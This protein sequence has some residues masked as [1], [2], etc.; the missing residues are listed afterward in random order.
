VL[1]HTIAKTVLEAAIEAEFEEHVASTS[2]PR[3]VPGNARNG[4]RSKTVRTIVGPI[5]IDVP[6]DRFG[7]FDPITVGKWQRDVVG[8]DRL[9]L[10]IVAK[11][12][13]PEKTL[14]LLTR[15]YPHRTPE[16]TLARIAA[17]VRARLTGWHDRSVEAR[18][19]R[20]EV[21]VS[22]QR[23]ENGRVAGF[24]F[25]SIVGVADP[26]HDGTSH[27]EL[28]S[29]HAF[30]GDSLDVPWYGVLSDLRRRG[31]SGVRCVVH[32]G[33]A[34]LHEVVAKVWPGACVMS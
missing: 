17:T 23:N 7:T 22:S 21:H 29:V 5:T 9:L 11:G 18:F 8:V 31:L 3:Q 27:R 26:D 12:A 20:L 24:P 10:P 4:R 34:A 32:D 16:R 13:P 15:A 19:P 30:P 6:R 28:L 25:V 2:S 14:A 33:S 1:F